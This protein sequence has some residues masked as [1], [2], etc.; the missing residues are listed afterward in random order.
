MKPFCERCG[1]LLRTDMS[2]GE[3]LR[4]CPRCGPSHSGASTP[5]QRTEQTGLEQRDGCDRF[6]LKRG[7]SP[8]SSRFGERFVH[9]RKG[10]HEGECAPNRKD[11]VPFR[12]MKVGP[13]VKDAEAR[14]AV[15]KAPDFFP[16]DL[17]RPGQSE[18]MQDA[19]TSAEKGICLLA[20]VPTGLG[21]TA[22]SL[23]AFLEVALEE[24]KLVTFL[25]SKQSQHSIAVDTMRR[26]KARTRKA[27]KVVDMT[28]KQSMCPRE[29]SHLPHS[30]FNFACRIQTK[31]QTCPYGK[32]PSRT[33]V[34]AILSEVHDVN[35][36][37]D[38]S[39]RMRVCPHKAALEAAREA[40]VLICDYN[41]IFSDL[42]AM[43]LSGIGKDISDI[44]VI[45]DE[46]HNL[47][48]RIRSQGSNDLSLRLVQD[49]IDIVRGTPTLSLPLAA[50][51]DLLIGKA[52]K[53]VRGPWEL[54]LDKKA[55]I[56]ELKSAVEG[57][58]DRPLDPVAL[59][60][61]LIDASKR[62]GLPEDED[63]LL[64]ISDHLEGLFELRPSH[65]LFLQVPD[66]RSVESL[67]LSYKDL[68]PSDISAPVL[69][70]CRASIIMS[71][72]L[73]PPGMFGDVLG[74]P[75]DRRMERVYPSPFPRENRLVLLDGSVTTAYTSR[76]ENMFRVTGERVVS[77]T[78]RFPGN[79]AAF[80]P[81]YGLMNEVKK[82]LWGCPKKVLVEERQMGRQEKDG[83]IRELE[84]SKER[85]GALLLAVMGG[86]LS[87][88]VDYKDNLLSGVLVIGLP[89]APPTLETKALRG[90]YRG[91]FGAVKGDEYA[92][93]YPAVN[94]VLQAAGRSTRSESDRSVIVM[95]EKR[96]SD[97]RYLKF[98]PPEAYP[99]TIPG[100]PL[101]SV[102]DSFFS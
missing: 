57:A 2:G 39:A 46:G 68:D 7:V 47:P 43:V 41:H 50:I 71:G 63:P 6:A 55:F 59:P 25:T 88:G 87:E 48:D 18:F 102:I 60:D 22:A 30:S 31:D 42:S 26:L 90:L 100:R 38:E 93:V 3:A 83:I 70:S 92:Y 66:G 72:T 11:S 61:L 69:R 62:R 28:S 14:T 77:L 97:E 10:E 36:I 35:W 79:V 78:G 1:S 75:R 16:F 54:E 44:M 91:K 65:L 19:K 89:F 98:L 34:Q 24:E 15:L 29:I 5:L 40:N 27:L 99:R 20:N 80:F 86:S 64:L 101:E 23:S 85:G 53:D 74:V 56:S 73:S 76:N 82:N 94:R 67:R 33:L 17:V 8:K 84:R 13:E 9:G 45:V 52:G 4:V 95:M 21:K 49:A 58:L 51:R 32:T 37:V 96:L 12:S 81:S